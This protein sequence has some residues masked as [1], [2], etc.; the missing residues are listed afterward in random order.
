L[1][2]P[3]PLLVAGTF[4][5]L[6]LIWG[7]TWAAIRIGLEGIPPFAG[8]ALRFGIAAVLLFA[9]GRMIGV[10]FGGGRRELF[11]WVVNALMS[12]CISYG[13]VYW[14]EQ[15]VPS[16]L[17]A[18]LFAT[19]PLF[20]AMLA[21]FALP[22]ERLAL[23]GVAGVLLGFG[24]VAVI[25][26]EDLALLGGPMVALAATV[27]LLSPAAAAVASVAVKRWGAGMHPFSLTAVPM[28]MTA[29]IMGAVSFAVE[30]DAV[31]VFERK[32]VGALLYLAVL[33]SA[34]T[35]SLYFWL[36]AHIPA[37]RVSMIAYLVPLVAVG[38]GAALFD[39]SL[40]ARTLAGALLVVIGV[41]L[42]VR[43]GRVRRPRG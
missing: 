4:T 5:L 34:V 38:V 36:L 14:A 8:V 37:T 1:S 17:A 2:R 24:G 19:F 32:S 28:A 33:G 42:T 12:F 15:W 40:T 22:G 30:R 31:F 3:G 11:V 25:F 39:E 7:T 18:V 27:M 21:H 6:V 43:G 10:R 9:A 35:F 41:A 20:V 29:V 23:A 26:S 13:V 16:G